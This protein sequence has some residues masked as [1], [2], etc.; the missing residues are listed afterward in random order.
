M[1]VDKRLVTKI[2]VTMTLRLS[3]CALSAVMLLLA[4][5]QTTPV[6]ALWN[7]GT[8]EKK[9]TP[10]SAPVGNDS[11]GVAADHV[12]VEYGVDVS[13]PMQHA[14]VSDNYAWLPHNMDPVHT[15]VP[16]KYKDKVVQP[17]GD[18]QAIYDEFIGGCKETWG[19]K[20]ARRCDSNEADRIAMTL[21]QPQSM[22]VSDSYMYD[23]HVHRYSCI[24]PA[25]FHSSELYR[26]RL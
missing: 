1:V 22:Q 23:R 25:T 3:S 15:D 18:R 11:N 17:L 21:R 24:Q 7:K 16:S 6:A 2:I 12:P 20:G 10:E 13:F 26:C 9:G 14:K 8:A 19:S 4:T 5:S